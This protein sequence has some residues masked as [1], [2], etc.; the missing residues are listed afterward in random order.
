VAFVSWAFG[1]ALLLVP[2][3]LLAGYGITLDPGST[4]IA[5][6]FGGALVGLDPDLLLAPG[7][8]LERHTGTDFCIVEHTWTGRLGTLEGAAGA[9][10]SACSTS[11]SSG[12]GG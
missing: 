5:R 8:G 1:L 12:R 2:A 7:E 4:I 3:A 10:R 11:S 6:L 9:S